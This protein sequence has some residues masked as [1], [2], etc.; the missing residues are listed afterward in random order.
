[1]QYL[2]WRN[3]V[4]KNKRPIAQTIPRLDTVVIL[5]KRLSVTVL[6]TWTII[7]RSGGG[8]PSAEEVVVKHREN[9]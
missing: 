4:L 9:E 6:S 5:I 1:M 8:L 3:M 2:E 7:V